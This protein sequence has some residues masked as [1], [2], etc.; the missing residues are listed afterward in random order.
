MVGK[1]LPLVSGA[2]PGT[3]VDK[4][5]RLPMTALAARDCVFTWLECTAFAAIE[6]RLIA[7]NVFL[8]GRLGHDDPHVSKRAFVA[9]ISVG[10]RLDFPR[11]RSAITGPWFVQFRATRRTPEFTS[12]FPVPS[13]SFGAL[14]VGTEY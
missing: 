1:G 2:G 10:A 9:D 14:T 5:H 3:I 8:D 12:T 11:T 13:Q 7:H 4:L 6:G